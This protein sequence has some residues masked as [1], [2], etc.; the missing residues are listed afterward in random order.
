MKMSIQIKR[1][2]KN[3]KRLTLQYLASLV[4]LLF[5]LACA[6]NPVTKRTEFVLMS[7]QQEIEFGRQENP[8]ILKKYGDYDSKTLQ[9]Y[10]TQV[11]QKLARISDRP[12]LVFHFRVVNSPVL[13][14]FALPGGYVYVTRGLF[15]YINSEAELAG[16]IGHEIGHVNARHAVKQYTQAAGYQIASGVLSIFVPQA[17][18]LGQLSD[19]IFVGISRGYSREYELEADQLGIKYAALAGYDPAGVQSF[20]TSLE[21]VDKATNEK[22]YHGLFSTHPETKT[23]IEKAIM[24]IKNSPSFSSQK[25]ATLETE[26]KNHIDGLLYGTDPKEGVVI[27]NVFRHP[28]LRIEV[29]LPN[30]WKINNESDLLSASHPQKEYHIQMMVQDMGK[31]MTADQLARLIAQKNN[32]REISGSATR[33]NGLEAYVGTYQGNVQQLGVIGI[34]GG[35]IIHGDKIYSL[36]G[37]CPAQEFKNAENFFTTTIYSFRELT[38][39]EAEKI[40]PA[41]IRLY[42]VQ[43][44]DTFETIASKTGESREEAKTLALMNGFNASDTPPV[45]KK[46]KVIEKE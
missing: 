11:G 16:V 35:F 17:R 18:N 26:Y 34:K 7:E 40:K 44:G 39:Q 27:K 29:T 6:V 45:G 42:V 3:S 15:A 28:D 38:L 14:A 19:I 31:R 2:M 1:V 22:T 10:A 32:L 33:I 13:N 4:L 5:S 8:N 37:F 9:D 23:R 46:I 30:D 24:E 41:R 25:F 36:L 12:D 20:L 21:R 43:K